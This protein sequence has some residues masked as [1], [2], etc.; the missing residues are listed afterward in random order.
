MYSITNAQL[1]KEKRR[2]FFLGTSIN[3]ALYRLSSNSIY[4][5]LYVHTTTLE[6]M[7]QY[8]PFYKIFLGNKLKISCKSANNFE[9]LMEIST[10]P[11]CTVT[12]K[13]FTMNKLCPLAQ[14]AIFAID[15]VQN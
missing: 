2:I 11:A 5:S 7:S 8:A 9:L 15:V 3:C 13:K 6:F 14:D 4:Y 12:L 10:K 1:L